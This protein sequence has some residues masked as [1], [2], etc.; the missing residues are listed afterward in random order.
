MTAVGYKAFLIG[1]RFMTDPNPAEAIRALI[2][3]QRPRD[4][5]RG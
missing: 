2:G 3:T 1:E 4:E 5:V